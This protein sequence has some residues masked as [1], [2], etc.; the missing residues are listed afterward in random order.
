MQGI[1]LLGVFMLVLAMVAEFGSLR[2]KTLR[3]QSAF[4]RAALA[5]TGAVDGGALADRGELRLDAAAAEAVAREY[6]AANLEPF[7]VSIPGLTASG[8][9]AAARVGVSAAPERAVTLSGE[10]ELPS[11]LL[12]LAGVGP[13]VT[14]RIESHSVLEGP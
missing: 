6:L 13:T 4:D 7:E 10:V 2:A 5:A 12:A 14:Y 9:A 11:G 1:L 3:L 8:T